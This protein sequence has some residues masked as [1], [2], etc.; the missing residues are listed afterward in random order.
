MHRFISV[1]ATEMVK[2]LSYVY[3]DEV[4]TAAAALMPELLKSAVSSRDKGLCDQNF[5]AGLANLVFDKL[6]DMVKEE[7]EPE[8]QPRRTCKVPGCD[9]PAFEGVDSR[10][11]LKHECCSRSHAREVCALKD[12]TKLVF[13]EKGGKRHKYC[14]RCVRLR[15]CPCAVW[16]Q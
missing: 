13:V 10:T 1:V 12:C 6:I 5:V 9:K 8:V 11:G 2:T 7:P 15:P 14:C 3:S 16:P 4:R